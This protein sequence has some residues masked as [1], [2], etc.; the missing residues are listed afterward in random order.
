MNIYEGIVLF[1]EVN[2]NCKIGYIIVRD[3]VVNFKIVN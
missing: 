2:L 3:L 1:N